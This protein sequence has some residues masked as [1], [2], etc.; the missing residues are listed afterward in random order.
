MLG[1]GSRSLC[2]GFGVST[3]GFMVRVRVKVL[4]FGVYD[5]EFWGI[6]FRVYGLRFGV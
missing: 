2:L 6:W 1:L 5:L 4:D 3:L